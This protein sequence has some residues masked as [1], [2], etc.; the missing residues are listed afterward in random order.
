[1]S[2]I[3]SLIVTC[4]GQD[5]QT[6]LPRLVESLLAQSEIQSK[7]F[8]VIFV[9]ESRAKDELDFIAEQTARF[10]TNQARMLSQGLAGSNAG[11]NLAIL[12]AKGDWLLFCSASDYYDPHYLCELAHAIY[13]YKGIGV[14]FTNLKVYQNKG[15]K[16]QHYD[17]HNAAPKA[18]FDKDLDDNVIFALDEINDLQRSAR[19]IAFNRQLILQEKVLFRED[20]LFGAEK[21]FH[22]AYLFALK[23]HVE[24]GDSA[25]KLGYKSVFVKSA[26]MYIQPAAVRKTQFFKENSFKS[27]DLIYAQT[28]YL[29][30]AYNLAQENDFDVNFICDNFNII[31]Q[32]VV[33]ALD[34]SP[35]LTMY[36]NSVRNELIAFMNILQH[37]M[38]L[39][40]DLGATVQF[41]DIVAKEKF[42]VKVNALPYA[43]F[44]QAIACNP[45]RCVQ[46]IDFLTTKG[47]LVGIDS[48][49]VGKH[50]SVVPAAS[51]FKAVVKSVAKAFKSLFGGRTRHADVVD[52]AAL[53][54]DPQVSA[55]A[56]PSLENNSPQQKITY[57]Q[58]NKQLVNN[59]SELAYLYYRNI[60]YNNRTPYLVIITNVP[61]RILALLESMGISSSKLSRNIVYRVSGLTVGRQI[62]LNLTL[63]NKKEQK[64]LLNYCE[65]VYTN[66]SFTY[67]R[68]SGVKSLAARWFGS[69]GTAKRNFLAYKR[70]DKRNY[71]I[72]LENIS[73]L[74][75]LNATKSQ[76]Q[77]VKLINSY[78]LG[79]NFNAQ[80]FVLSAR[81]KEKYHIPFVQSESGIEQVLNEVQE[82]LTKAHQLADQ[83]RYTASGEDLIAQAQI[84]VSA[85]GAIKQEESKEN[86]QNSSA[87]TTVNSEVILGADSL[88][89]NTDSTDTT[90]LDESSITVKATYASALEANSSNKTAAITPSSQTVAREDNTLDNISSSA[91]SSGDLN[92]HTIANDNVV[93]NSLVEDVSTDVKSAKSYTVS[94]EETESISNGE[95]N[96]SANSLES[97]TA[98]S[99]IE[100]EIVNAKEEQTAEVEILSQITDEVIPLGAE[101]TDDNL[102]DLEEVEESSS[103]PSEQATTI[104][105]SELFAP[106]RIRGLNPSDYSNKYQPLAVEDIDLSSKEQVLRH[107]INYFTKFVGLNSLIV[108]LSEVLDRK[109]FSLLL[110][111][112]NFPLHDILVV[113][114]TVA[115][116]YNLSSLTSF[117]NLRL[118]FPDVEVYKLWLDTMKY[119]AASEEELD[120]EQVNLK[121]FQ[122]R[123]DIWRL[124]TRSFVLVSNKITK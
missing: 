91:H 9:T 6:N 108:P 37:W 114:D 33:Y 82:T 86:A 48:K 38:E 15:K 64:R 109:N 46:V 16:I 60:Y 99:S 71:L 30:T 96:E 98:N 101:L 10:P 59:A 74:L 52:N 3:F 11:R 66:N 17:L 77:E 40:R 63:L 62:L 115:S 23:K 31:A 107:K 32:S 4:V 105:L 21:I 111:P 1:M 104:A 106:H 55:P 116:E 51:G 92:T 43:L 73:K 54:D 25:F 13:T 24:Q 42:F 53:L 39:I 50:L 81:Q 20:V 94:K 119:F 76:E 19:R 117:P 65:Q 80:D 28:G 27:Q 2:T 89:I 26:L 93:L 85:L 118:V 72:Q 36:N 122:H 22:F 121:L 29:L 41:L 84:S 35:S 97:V 44:L 75:G 57:S 56:E 95:E 34:F 79:Y 113:V 18:I 78:E 120:K 8:E 5:L 61:N 68:F 102:L 124:L 100:Q 45:E 87:P 67:Y 123:Y 69:H 110:T 14:F 7:D 70:S 90:F 49:E 47:P 58:I 112:P 83:A 12:N 88:A 103:L